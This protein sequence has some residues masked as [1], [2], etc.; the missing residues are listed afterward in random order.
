MLVGLNRFTSSDVVRT[1]GEDELVNK[2]IEADA[3]GS[4]FS[5]RP[6]Y[7]CGCRVDA[8]G[9]SHQWGGSLWTCKKWACVENVC[10]WISLTYR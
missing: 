1:N 8:I 6:R 2:A 7:C 5:V 4:R 3:S 9:S 10:E